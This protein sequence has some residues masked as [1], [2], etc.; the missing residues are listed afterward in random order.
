MICSRNGLNESLVCLNSGKDNA[1]CKGT[2]YC[3]HLVYSAT[4]GKFQEYGCDLP[5]NHQAVAM[6]YVPVHG[7]NKLCYCGTPQCNEQWIVDS[8]VRAF[9]S[10]QIL[11]LIIG[12]SLLIVSW[13]ILISYAVSCLKKT[14]INCSLLSRWRTLGSTEKCCTLFFSTESIYFTPG[15]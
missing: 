4:S 8:A 15:C 14:P 3:Y 1:L 13:N 7:N 5:Q 12:L 6:P 2:S 9:T 11:H 10:G